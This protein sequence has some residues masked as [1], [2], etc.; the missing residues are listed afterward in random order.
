MRI[1]D[2][3][4]RIREIFGHKDPE[5][6][7][8]IIRGLIRSLEDQEPEEGCSCDEVFALMDQYADV[9]VRG[10]D[11]ARLMPLLRNHMDGCHDCNEEYEALLEILEHSK[12]E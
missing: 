5:L 10:E 11:A 1:E 2:F 12:S 7:D 9:E 3:V 6:P 8:E 4:Q